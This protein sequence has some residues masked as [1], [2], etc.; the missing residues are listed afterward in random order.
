MCEI[1]RSS[2]AGML[3][4]D[5][6]PWGNKKYGPPVRVKLKKTHHNPSTGTI[7]IIIFANQVILQIKLT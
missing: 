3:N 4:V 6:G 2:Q 1:L 5:L 7:V